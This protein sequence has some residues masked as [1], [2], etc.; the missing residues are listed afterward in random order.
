MGELESYG[1]D[2]S[3]LREM[4]ELWCEGANKSEL[5]RR[6]LGRPQSHGKLFTTLVRE[7]LGVETEQKSHLKAE[8]DALSAE[9][10][11]LKG[12]LRENGIDPESGRPLS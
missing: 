11:R 2:I 10:V 7:H 8:R 6:Y 3:T 4:Y 5:E 12:L 9:V 1:I